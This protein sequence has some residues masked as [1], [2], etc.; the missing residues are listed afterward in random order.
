MTVKRGLE[1]ELGS[2]IEMMDNVRTNGAVIRMISDHK[3]TK[4][5]NARRP[6]ECFHLQSRLPASFR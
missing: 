3:A 6:S 5:I 4:R 2:D 1:G